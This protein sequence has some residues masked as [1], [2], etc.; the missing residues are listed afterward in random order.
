MSNNIRKYLTVIIT[1]RENNQYSIQTFLFKKRQHIFYLMFLGEGG[2]VRHTH[3]ICTAFPNMTCQGV[4]HR[5]QLK[6]F[7]NVSNLYTY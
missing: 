2:G 3:N 1:P 7:M 5:P 4:W 6:Y